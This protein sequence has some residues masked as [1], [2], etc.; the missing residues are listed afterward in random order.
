MSVNLL[1]IV[2]H[3]VYYIET[4]NRCTFVLYYISLLFLFPV[5]S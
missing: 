4:E 1:W 2:D 3:T 5:H